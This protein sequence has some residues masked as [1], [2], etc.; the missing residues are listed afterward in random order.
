MSQ[1]FTQAMN[2]YADSAIKKQRKTAKTRK[3]QKEWEWEDHSH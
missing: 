3:E 2:I 1:Q